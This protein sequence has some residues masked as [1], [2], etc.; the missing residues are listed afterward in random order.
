MTV[1]RDHYYK[2]SSDIEQE[3][4][5]S[6]IALLTEL[7][8]ANDESE[9][10]YA[11]TRLIKGLSSS[12]GSSRV[13]F[14]TCL[15]EL[16]NIRR[17]NGSLS[18]KQLL[19]LINTNTKVS[20]SM[21][22]KE[23]RAVLFGKLFG[24]QC[25]SNVNSG[26]FASDI[27]SENFKLF[28]DNLFDLASQKS[29]IREPTLFT[30]VGL[31]GSVYSKLSEDLILYVFTKLDEYQLSLTTEGVALYLSVPSTFR[32]TTLNSTTFQNPTWKEADPLKQVNIASLAKVL[33]DVSTGDDSDDNNTK[34]NNKKKGSWSPR[35]HFVWPLIVKEL[36]SLN[37]N[38]NEPID[39]QVE[40]SK[41]RKKSS[42]EGRKKSKSNGKN[43]NNSTSEYINIA[44]FWKVIIDEGFFSEK[45][46]HERKFWGFEIFELLFESV[47]PEQ[48]SPLFTQNFMRTLINQTS[49]SNRLLNK[50]AKKTLNKIT[51]ISINQPEKIIH[52]LQNVLIGDFGSLQFDRLTKSK[53]VEKLLTESKA[54]ST[55][56]K[57]FI[58]VLKNPIVKNQDSGKESELK[59]QKW[60]IDQ[61]LHLVRGKKSS[62]DI[63][64]DL[65]W[66][67]SV[68]K[69]LVHIAFFKKSD[70]EES[71]IAEF[72][73]ERLNSILSDV[74]TIERT[75]NQ[76]W[77]FKTLS[78]LTEYSGEKVPIFEFDE[79][80]GSVKDKSLKILKKIRNKRESSKHIDN[81]RLLVFELLF[82]MVTIQLF[83]GG[84]ESV[85]T[86]QELQDYYHA[87]K[88]ESADDEDNDDQQDSIIGIVEILLNFVS[89]KSSLLKKLSMIVW[90]NFCEKI[91][92][93]ALELLFDVI[94]T[95]ENK[96]GQ[97]ALFEGEDEFVDEDEE[98]EEHSH[99]HDDDDDEDEE[100]SDSESSGD[101]EDEDEDN[102]EVSELDKKT[103]LALAEALNISQHNGEVTFSSDDEDDD[104]SD[105]SMDDEQMMA[106]DGQLS[107]IFKQRR[108][109]LDNIQTGN[110]R[111]AEV[112][113]ARSNILLF[114]HRILDLLETFAKKN[115]NSEL[116]VYTVEPLLTG[117][118]LTLDKSLGT[119]IHKLLKNRICKSKIEIKT[120]DKDY[121]FELL[122]NIQTDSLKTS[123][124][125]DFN[126]SSSQCSIF[127]SKQ[128]LALDETSADLIIDQYTELLKKWWTKKNSRLTSSIFFDFINWLSSKRSQN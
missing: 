10:E 100:E 20:S 80:L 44:E 78:F 46:S 34:G 88:K 99:D 104:M 107:K 19:E 96:E 87:H 120:L 39:Q 11:L 12:R 40:N 101:E 25:I 115:P 49:D 75:D 92:L 121:L 58:N 17:E 93:G 125:N 106:I 72:A 48:S 127:I 84:A 112:Q 41:K 63:E 29:W 60:A 59:T 31:L 103:N 8:E 54:N 3:R 57:F 74:V 71:P 102:D 5:T 114:K 26:V 14:S 28:T 95:K 51:E 56:A 118:K 108:D 45:A 22:G 76:T 94:K 23:E 6:S 65:K 36:T 50:V 109:A 98:E 62:I 42:N 68:L 126:L 15:T 77:S 2:L 35:L 64:T 123:N 61:L 83:S 122:K 90:E 97:K 105:E 73:Q 66:L 110:K 21:N 13:G 53:T 52:V 124:T 117:L 111:K 82:S 81:S 70:E 24:L 30:M 16:I 7:S 128:I 27:S 86:L 9:W 37:N 43:P 79:E 69:S 89:Q 4:I 55:I 119:K 32:N 1:S 38:N 91:D 47:Q 85:D 67:D 116:L 18:L 33:K 113:D